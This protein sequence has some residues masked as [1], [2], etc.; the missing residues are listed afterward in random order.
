ME[1]P[2]HILGPDLEHSIYRYTDQIYKVV[3]WKIPRNPFNFPRAPSQHYDHKLDS[4]LS[5][6]KSEVLELAL[7][8]QWDYFCT[9]TIDPLKFDRNDLHG[10]HKTFLQWL[11]DQRKKGEDFDF[12]LVPELHDK[13]GW[14]AHGLFR[15]LGSQNLVSFRDLDQSGFRLPSGRRIKKSLRE[16]DY[17][18]WLPY[19]EKFGYNSFGCLRNPVASAFYVSK[20]ITKDNTKSV[21]ELGVHKYW[22][23]R[24][25]NRRTKHLDFIG[26]S[27]LIDRI[28]ENDY[29]FCRTGFTHLSD[30]FDWSFALEYLDTS[31]LEYINPLLDVSA[32][33]EAESV[34]EFDQLKFWG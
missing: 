7:C 18:T 5:R 33:V 13:G 27:F 4:S 30:G 14:H 28:V 16:S 8:N 6:T 2:L 29:D 31:Q 10:W 19:Y 20:Y 25:L 32:K 9:F 15:G 11:R 34:Y 3:Q 24:G 1:R 21:T 23:S 12:L 22:P 26:R 17:M